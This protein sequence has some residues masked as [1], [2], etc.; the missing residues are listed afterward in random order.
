MP[1]PQTLVVVLNW[2]SQEMTEECV[3]SVLAME[4]DSFELLIVD[5]GSKDGSPEY[6]R[7]AFPDI[8]VIANSR[9]LGFTGGCNVG[10]KRALE[11]GADYVLLVNNDTVVGRTFLAD[12][13][14]ESAA[15]PKAGMVSPKIYYFEPQNR[16]WWAGGVFNLWQGIPRHIGWRQTEA[17]RY[18]TPVT[19]DWATGCGVLLK[20]A[21]LRETGLFD[22]RIFANGEDLD[23]SLRMRNLGWQIRY[24]PRAKMW[25]KEGFATRRN[26]GEYA[27]KFTATRNVL[28]VMHKHARGAHWITFWPYFLVRYVFV[29]A[30]K[31][32]FRGDWKSSLAT[33]SGIFAFFRM[34][35]DP[36][37]SPLPAALA[38]SARVVVNPG[39][40]SAKVT[41]P[42]AGS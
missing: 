40:V 1:T 31:S 13:L 26:V 39:H 29:I 41:N 36:E 27:R 20:S 34:R 28:Y 35:I 7:A 5:N 19:I 37:S 33:F 12:L 8:E 23:L 38:K 24:A 10:M 32:L 2:N 17:G 30:L 15:N 9:N 18:E 42:E 4:G 11:R 6:L 21:A 3:R 22:E 14:A 25:H 16:I